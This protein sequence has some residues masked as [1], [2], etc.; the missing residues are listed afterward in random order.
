LKANSLLQFLNSQCC[1]VQV[2][3]IWLNKAYL[4][5]DNTKV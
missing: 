1:A 2:N 3:M 5:S 4:C